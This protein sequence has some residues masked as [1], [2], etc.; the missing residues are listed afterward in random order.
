[1]YFPIKENFSRIEMFRPFD[2]L[3]NR[4]KRKIQRTKERREGIRHPLDRIVNAKIKRN[5]YK[6][7]VQ[8]G[9]FFR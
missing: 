2:I 3:R 9:Q 6:C 5:M 1:M 8:Q 7:V 4:K